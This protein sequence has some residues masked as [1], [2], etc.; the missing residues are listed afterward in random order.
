MGSNF[1]RYYLQSHPDDQ[2]VNL[3]A[4][5]YAGNLENLRDV[6][7]DG[8]YTFV[9]GDITDEVVVDHVFKTYSPSLV[10]NFAAETHVDRSILGPKAFILTDVIGTYTLLE[11]VKKYG[12]DRYLQVSTDEVYGSIKEGKFTEQSRFEPNSPYSASKAG[13]D[14]LVRAYNKT[15]GLPTIQTHSCNFFGPYQYPEKLIPLFSTNLM[16][17]LKV[18]MYGDG[19]NVREWIYV[20]DY[21][22]ALDTILA[23][24]AIGDVYNIDSGWERSNKDVTQALLDIFEKGDDMIEYV[25]DR[26]GHDWRY[27]VDSSKLRD[28]GWEPS[29]TFE[30][31]LRK[32][33][34]WYKTNEAWWKPLKEA[35]EHIN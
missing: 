19:S 23:K 25:D 28:L 16:E 5:T 32:T 12:V 35:D 11:A 18:P 10:V 14:H 31:Q 17:D 15:Y 34:E 29:G 2:V 3:D 21:C 9:K 30:G 1:V 20:D 33:V 22:R 8:R 24:G 27:A 7:N 4:L 26:L 13:G 6:E